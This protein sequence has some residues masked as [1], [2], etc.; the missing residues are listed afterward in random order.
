MSHTHYSCSMIHFGSGMFLWNLGFYIAPLQPIASAAVNSMTWSQ[1][2]I[3]S[4]SSD[5]LKLEWRK[6][7]SSR[8]KGRAKE[9]RKWDTCS[10]AQEPLWLTWNTLKC[11]VTSTFCSNPAWKLK[12]NC[13][14]ISIALIKY[15]FKRCDLMLSNK[16]C[17][18]KNLVNWWKRSVDQRTWQHRIR[19]T[20]CSSI[21]IHLY[22]SS[23]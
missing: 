18:A 22:N 16:L 10:N 4:K 23:G 8:A 5:A 21:Y 13:N 15:T 1:H 7:P 2:P 17:V 11:H 6:R 3:C 20:S 9:P 14:H 12:C 19:K